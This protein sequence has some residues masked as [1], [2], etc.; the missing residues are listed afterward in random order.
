[1]NMEPIG[2]EP[3]FASTYLTENWRKPYSKIAKMGGDLWHLN[4]WI[5]AYA[6][7]EAA[8]IKYLFEILIL[9]EQNHS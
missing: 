6:I 8:L 1:M 7:K 3:I 9:K 5:F 2:M 4:T